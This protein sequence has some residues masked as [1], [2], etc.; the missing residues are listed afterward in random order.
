MGSEGSGDQAEVEPVG[1]PLYSQTAAHHSS[2]IVRLNIIKRAT[3]TV[4]VEIYKWYNIEVYK[5]LGRFTTSAKSAP[6]PSEC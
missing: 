2:K 6:P 5:F 1:P 4:L 3:K